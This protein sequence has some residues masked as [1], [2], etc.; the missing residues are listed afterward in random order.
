MLSPW[1]LD[2]DPR[3]LLLVHRCSMLG[4]CRTGRH[5]VYGAPS[6]IPTC[7]Q[8]SRRITRRCA[9]RHAQPHGAADQAWRCS[10]CTCLSAQ[11]EPRAHGAHRGLTLLTAGLTLMSSPRWRAPRRHAAAPPPRPARGNAVPG[12][13]VWGVNSSPRWRAP[14]RPAAAPPPRPAPRQSPPG[15]PAPPAQPPPPP[16][17]AA[18]P[19][20]RRRR[21]RLRR[22]PARPAAPPAGRPVRARFSSL[23]LAPFTPRP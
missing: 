23:G 20:R 1:Q 8:P 21:H 11:T 15:A 22:P 16:P 12:F 17:A 19:G 13:M 5:H 6:S 10:A 14:R 2:A 7:H 9:Q 3:M 18:P 4:P